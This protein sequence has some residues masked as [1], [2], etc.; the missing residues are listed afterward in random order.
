MLSLQENTKQEIETRINTLNEIIKKAWIEIRK[1][2]DEKRYIK[3]NTKDEK[4]KILLL[5]I[6]DEKIQKIIEARDTANDELQNLYDE[7]Y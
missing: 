1:L 4:I 7:I 3:K 6:L 5:Y 2:V